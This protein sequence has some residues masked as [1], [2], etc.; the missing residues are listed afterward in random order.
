MPDSID[1]IDMRH[2]NLALVL[3]EII[4]DPR[5]RA[6]LAV[7][8]DMTKGA[9]GSLV[10]ELIDRGL[11]VLSKAASGGAVGRPGR[12][13]EAVTTRAHAVGIS[14]SPPYVIGTAVDLAGN[15]V[16]RE[17]VTLTERNTPIETLIEITRAIT[18]RLHSAVLA[19]SPSSVLAGVAVGVPDLVDPSA[20]VVRRSPTIGLTDY[21]LVR[22]LKSALNELTDVITIDN[23]ATYGAVAEARWLGADGGR[24]LLYLTGSTAMGG[25]IVANGVPFRGSTGYAGEVG[26]MVINPDGKLCVCG[27]LGCW[28]SEIG[29][30]TFLALAAEPED[31]VRD[32]TIDGNERI[33]AIVQ[34]ANA[35]DRRALQAIG[36]VARYLGLGLASLIN[37]FNPD[38]VIL[39]GYFIRLFPFL[40]DPVQQIVQQRVLSDQLLQCRILHSELEMYA[41]AIGAGISAID[42]FA[43]DPTAVPLVTDVVA[44]GAY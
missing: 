11:V 5:T 17:K 7:D 10:K 12:I 38:T 41:A 26:H 24:N 20:G 32:A 37:I 40:I 14:F 23:D 28:E 35:G 15:V 21:P 27:N 29:L 31:P 43:A 18:A 1:Q 16:A 4:R 22:A 30:N 8:I 34:R 25:G 6:Q 42:A 9:V 44:V 39:G 36:Q 3:A 19:S 13:V 2:S 33:T